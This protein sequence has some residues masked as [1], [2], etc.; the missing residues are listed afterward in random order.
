MLFL[1]KHTTIIPR[2]ILTTL[3]YLGLVA[4]AIAAAIGTHER[5]PLVGLVVLAGALWVLTPRKLLFGVVCA[6]TAGVV[7]VSAP[8]DWRERMSTIS[9]YDSDRSASTRILV[10]QW[11]LNYVMTHPLGGGFD[12]YRINRI[13]FAPDPETGEE[14]VQ[15]SRAYHS[16]YFEVLGEHGWIGLAL[17]GLISLLSFRALGKVTRL[18]RGRQELAF[19]HDLANALRVSLLVFLACGAFIGIAFQPTFYNLVAMSV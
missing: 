13:E 3:G 10:W 5:T 8:T 18:S 1:I 12:A 15:N 17:H 16:I 19:S 6:V 14:Q 11:T 4:L 9:T 2:G 7:L